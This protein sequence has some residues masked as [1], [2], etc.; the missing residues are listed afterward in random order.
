ME[1]H[2]S[3][4]WITR[5]ESF[6]FKHSPHLTK[7]V[8]ELASNERDMARKH[9]TNST[10]WGPDDEPRNAQHVWLNMQV[11]INPMVASLP[12]HAHLMAE[13]GCYAPRVKD[14]LGHKEC[15]TGKS[16]NLESTLPPSYYPLKLTP[17]QDQGWLD[18]MKQHI[19][20]NQPPPEQ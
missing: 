10:F 20:E 12:E 18:R 8:R 13:H 17:D 7:Q 15:G 5:F 2:D 3:D 14:K 6:G 19:A 16:G 4:W 9:P 11:F 1:V